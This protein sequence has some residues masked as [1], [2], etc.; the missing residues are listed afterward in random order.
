[1]PSRLPALGE[2]APWADGLR[3]QQGQPL[4]LEELAGRWVVLFFYPKDDTPGCTVEACEFSAHRDEID[5]VIIGVSR[6]DE[7]S[8]AAFA[9]K[10]GLELRLIADPEAKLCRLY[11]TAWDPGQKARRV[12][13]LIDPDQAIHAIW[14]EVTPAGHWQQIQQTLA[15][16]AR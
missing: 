13:F 5:A 1:M 7:A 8:H 3:D 14:P 9:A 16:A 12:T 15:A 6:D 4:S 10:H 2:R 11:G